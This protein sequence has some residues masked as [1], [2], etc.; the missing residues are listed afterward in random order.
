VLGRCAR[1]ASSLFA[2][3]D[4]NAALWGKHVDGVAVLS[5]AEGARLFGQTATFCVTIWRGEGTDTMSQRRAP[6]LADGCLNVIDFG[7][8]FWK[9][10][11]DCCRTILW[12]CRIVCWLVRTPFER[13][14][15]CGAMTCREPNT[16]PR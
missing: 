11:D 9:Y 10:G 7:A 3:V 16:L 1:T 2:F 14:S 4:N 12:I 15:T 13:A 8:L 5:P 6:L